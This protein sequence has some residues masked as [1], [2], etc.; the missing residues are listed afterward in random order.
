MSQEEN[1]CQ[2][3]VVAPII[4]HLKHLFRNKEHAKLL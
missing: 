2:G 1:P 4:A 3:D